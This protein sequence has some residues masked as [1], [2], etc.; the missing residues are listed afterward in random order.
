M[1]KK[2]ELL[3]SSLRHQCNQLVNSSYFHNVFCYANSDDINK[4]YWVGTGP[5]HSR[6]DLP[7]P[8]VY[9]DGESYM[10]TVGCHVVSHATFVL[11]LAYTDGDYQLNI[12][13]T[14][15]ALVKS[16]NVIMEIAEK[17]YKMIQTA[18]SKEISI[19]GKERHDIMEANRRYNWSWNMA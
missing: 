9:T 3:A 5:D 16:Y 14:P 4:E 2:R 10:A 19:L 1:G 12:H 13:V 6:I 7:S 11:E 18:I 8:S 17:Q 15:E